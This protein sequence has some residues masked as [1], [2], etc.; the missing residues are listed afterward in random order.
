LGTRIGPARSIAKRPQPVPF[1]SCLTVN[2]SAVSQTPSDKDRASVR[3]PTN[4]FSICHLS[5][6][7]T[8][9][10]AT[11]QSKDGENLSFAMRI[12][13]VLADGQVVHSLL[14]AL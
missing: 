12:P 3:K 7:G 5:E 9:E 4:T 13:G 8:T 2:P 11:A 6:A 14:N 1:S 10:G